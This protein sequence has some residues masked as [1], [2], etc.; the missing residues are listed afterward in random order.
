MNGNGLTRRDVL[1]STAGGA[2]VA[3]AVPGGA[4]GQELVRGD[5]LI[6]RWP[7]ASGL[8]DAVGGIDGTAAYGDPTVGSY[9]GRRAVRFDGDDGVQIGSGG[10]NPEMSFVESGDGPVTIAGWVYFDR[11]E[12]GKPN[13]EPASHHI[14]R[15]DAEYTLLATPETDENDT[16]EIAFRIGDLG[17]GESYTTLDHADDE[18]YAPVGRWNHFAFVVEPEESIRFH[19]NGEERFVDTEMNGYSPQNTNY[20]SHQTIG[21]WYGTGN[22]DWYDL[23]VGKL[24]DLRIYDGGL[25]AEE[26]ARIHANRSN[27]GSDDGS[28]DGESGG[29]GGDGSDE[30]DEGSGGDAGGDADGEPTAAFEYEPS[31]PA[32]ETQ[33]AFNAVDSAAPGSEIVSYEWEFGDGETG[34]G[35]TVTHAY[36]DPG[37]YNVRLTVTDD[38]DASA[39]T[40]ETVSVADG[41]ST[42]E[43]PGFGIGSGLAALGGAGYLLKRRADGSVEDTID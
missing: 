40:V 16:V 18:L 10:D 26:I 13:N 36:A 9:D 21:S 25:S 8:E 12:G 31:E 42:I 41:E 22:P 7:F 19:L 29:G 17:G 30:D 28:D 33:V 38:R 43:V 14:L 20:W 27:D 24:S 32:T 34:S 1:R 15:N 3:A 35:E 23:L 39:S 5:D 11:A 4:A 2:L 6:A 37:G